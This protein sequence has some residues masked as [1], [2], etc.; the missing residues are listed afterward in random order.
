MSWFATALLLFNILAE[1]AL[2]APS[3]AMAAAEG[4]A[5]S[6]AMEMCTTH[7]LERLDDHGRAPPGDT[8]VP[9]HKVHPQIC[10][11]CLLLLQ[12]GLAL[13][14]PS[15]IRAPDDVPVAPQAILSRTAPVVVARPP[16][17]NAP[18]APP[19]A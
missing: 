1:A 15:A 19:L 7:G 16:I 5:T 8:G 2:P 12:A 9:G 6:D 3:L 13:A 14:T 18:R 17:L 10:V 4:I 11:F